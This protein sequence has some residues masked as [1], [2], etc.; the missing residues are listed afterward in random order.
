MSTP[1][2]YLLEGRWTFTKDL[3]PIA[4]WMGD[5]PFPNHQ[6]WLAEQRNM[7]RR[8]EK[9]PANAGLA[10]LP[11][12]FGLVA[13]GPMTSYAVPLALLGPHQ[14]LID[15][16]V[17]RNINLEQFNRL[18]VEQGLEPITGPTPPIGPTSIG[19]ASAADLEGLRKAPS[20][21]EV[22]K[23]L[24]PGPTVEKITV[25]LPKR[26]APAPPPAPSVHVVEHRHVVELHIR[27]DEEAGA[28]ILKIGG[29]LMRDQSEQQ[30]R[31]VEQLLPLLLQGAPDCDGPAAAEG[32]APPLVGEGELGEDCDPSA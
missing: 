7:R 26:P 22:E 31:V 12:G 4:W 25:P 2:L 21:D 1:F 5:K 27:I 15:G 13:L 28:A 14:Q 11:D 29:Q 32:E 30:R 3:E 20:A 9:I 24:Q 10:A 17:M 6:G 23:P 18:R 16:V 8:N 19:E